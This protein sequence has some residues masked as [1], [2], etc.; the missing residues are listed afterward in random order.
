MA[1]SSFGKWLRVLTARRSLAF[2][3][4]MALVADLDPKRVEEH[5]RIERLERPVLPFGDLVEH[6]VGHRADQIRRHVPKT[7]GP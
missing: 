6:G 7:L 5:Q 2:K 4:S 1:L 3:A